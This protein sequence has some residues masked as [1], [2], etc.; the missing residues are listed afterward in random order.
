MY[1]KANS[2]IFMEK[3]KKSVNK[4]SVI[5]INDRTEAIAIIF[6][7]VAELLFDAVAYRKNCNCTKEEN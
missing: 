3:T 1:L 4:E 5:S 6:F 2:I 7:N